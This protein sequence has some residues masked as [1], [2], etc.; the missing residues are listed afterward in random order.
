MAGGTQPKWIIL[1]SFAGWEWRNLPGDLG[2]GLTLAAIAVPE[3]MATARLGGFAPEIGFYV[4]IV[5]TLAFA[6]FGAN[7]YLS[8]GADST[9]T[10]I[11]AGALGLLAAQ[12]SPAYGALAAALAL[13]V[14]AILIVSGLARLGWIASF[15]SAPVT[16][17]FLAGIA[18]HIVI[19]QLPALL[20]L[21]PSG[22]DLFAR[23]I[24]IATHIGETNLYALFL[25]ALVFAFSV[26]G[27]QWNWRVP[28]ALIGLAFAMLLVGVLGNRGVPVVGETV[29]TWP[30]PSMPHLTQSAASNLASLALLISMIVMVQ[31]A[32][33]TRAFTSLADPQDV[34]RDFIGVGAGSVAAGLFGLFPVNASPPRTAAVDQAG[35]RSQLS[36][37]F[38]V[39]CVALLIAFGGALLRYVPM[40]ALAGILF[41]VALRIARPSTFLL[42][43]RQS[44]GEFLLIL[45]TMIAIVALPIQT[46]VAVG[47]GLS[48]M[49]GLWTIT[50]THMIELEHVSGTTVWWPPMPGQQGE[51]QPG[52]RVV[53]FAAPLFFLNADNFRRDMICIIERD[54]PSLIVF[55]ASGV[56]DIDFTAARTLLEIIERCRDANIKLAIARLTS[57]R[58]QHALH[59]FGIAEKLGPEGFYHSVDEAIKAQR[60]N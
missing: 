37:L 50:R 21:A 8:S 26:V 11:F 43:L 16:T 28:G 51:K 57:L 49:H 1:R 9:I 18:I 19:S 60:K 29:M 22:S 14:G 10:P 53:A 56:A 33:T 48:I 31:T 55:E 42:V 38:A 27:E 25:G 6:L 20:D 46:G 5:G 15:L 24:W 7:R 23:C 13:A 47:I 45:A 36:G 39:V 34:N 41:S 58:A 44:W 3:Q 59:R 17:G 30:H 52:V 40:A 35:G 32:A 2:A 54:K 12:G 4:F